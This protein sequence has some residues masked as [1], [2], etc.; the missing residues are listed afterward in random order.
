MEER[1]KKKIPA[2]FCAVSAT[3]WETFSRRATSTSGRPAPLRTGRRTSATVC[4]RRSATPP[5]PLDRS[6][7]G[8]SAIF[9]PFSLPR[10]FHDSQSLLV[11]FHLVLRSTEEV[12]RLAGGVVAA[13]GVSSTA[14]GVGGGLSAPLAARR[15]RPTVDHLALVSTAMAGSDGATYRPRNVPFFTSTILYSF[16]Q[17]L[18]TVIFR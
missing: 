9:F 4:R 15:G 5:D 7:D 2:S 18:R 16:S 14:G 1:L 17:W 3:V 10:S 11:M 8:R 6:C 13:A 12:Y